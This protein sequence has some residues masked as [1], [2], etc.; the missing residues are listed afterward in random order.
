MTPRVLAETY[1]C[2][3][4]TYFFFCNLEVEKSIL[5][6]ET[7]SFIE[8]SVTYNLPSQDKGLSCKGKSTFLRKPGKLPLNDKGSCPKS[9]IPCI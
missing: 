9:R 1:R 4:K 2:H 5:K 3:I 6:M 7:V 8:I